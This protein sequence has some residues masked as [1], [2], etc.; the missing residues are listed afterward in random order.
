[1][2]ATGGEFRVNFDLWRWLKLLQR[3]A[4][5]LASDGANDL[6][7]ASWRTPGAARRRERGVQARAFG[8]VNPSTESDQ[9]QASATTLRRG[10]HGQPWY[11]CGGRY[12]TRTYDLVRVKHA[13]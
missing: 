8:P 13:L 9:A 3:P 12:R 5:R 2:P 6:R 10:Y 1:M 4:I 11:L 7:T